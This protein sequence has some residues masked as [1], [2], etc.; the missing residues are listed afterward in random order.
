[1]TTSFVKVL[2]FPQSEVT[3]DKPMLGGVGFIRNPFTRA[4]ARKF[5]ELCEA[6]GALECV[7]NTNAFDVKFPYGPFT[8]PAGWLE[9]M[10]ALMAT[11]FS[12]DTGFGDGCGHF[13]VRLA[14]S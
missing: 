1:M 14:H 8:A 7:G 3:R 13:T 9:Q 11:V 10:D 12:S 2:D 6:W 4:R 5:Y